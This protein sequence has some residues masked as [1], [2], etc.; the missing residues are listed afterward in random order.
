MLKRI[1]VQ[2][3]TLGMYLKDFCGSWMEHPFWRS[4]FVITDPKDLAS[5]RASSI[6]EVWID[7][8]KGLDLAPDDSPVAVAESVA[9]V[10]IELAST[11]S[12][13]RETASVSSGVEFARAARIVTRSREAI[14]A[15]FGEARMGKAIDS[16]GAQRLVDEISDSMS[17]NPGAL[18]SIARLK[19]AD[20]YTYMHSVAVCGLMVTLARQLGLDPQQTQSAGLA[21]LL[22]DLGKA[23]IPTAILNKPG[24]LT[25]AEFTL[26]KSHPEKGHQI[27]LEGH[28]ADAIALDVVLHH[29]EKTDG[30]GYP[31]RLK[32]DDIS[33]FAKMGAVCDVYDAITSDR[34]YKAGWCPA[35]SLRRMNEWTKG[36][37]EPRVFQAFVKTIGI[38][39]IGTLVRL[40]C[41]RLGVVT[42]Q[43][44][45]SLLRPQ[46][47]VFFSTRSNE[48]I[49]PTVIDLA[50]ADAAYKI[51][52][53]E[54]PEKWKFSNL[55]AIW[56]GL[57]NLPG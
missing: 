26:V 34:P 25:D 42:E 35:E 22:H 38:Y 18:V 48:R 27:L 40:S 53:I 13:K 32:G 47:K 24:R 6:T 43:G 28:G 36:H 49:L 12:K 10:D 30:S 5:I 4:A 55:S 56:S 37:F 3:L 29:H 16:V 45:H 50:H 2:Q 9:E 23:L 57:P 20:N 52:N 21:G 1:S 33:L 7:C 14:T 8:A 31:K 39:P 46:V 17:R 44:S 54:D 19:T 11:A 15:M 51:V 41:G